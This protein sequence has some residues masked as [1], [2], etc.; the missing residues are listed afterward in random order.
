MAFVIGEAG[1]GKTSLLHAFARRAQAAQPGLIVASGICDD[2]TGVGDPYL[3]FRDV[4]KMLSGDVETQWAAGDISRDHAVRLWHL[5][6]RTARALV[7]H[8]PD[9]IGSFI[10]GELLIQRVAAYQRHGVAKGENSAWL[11]RLQAL[12][13]QRQG[14]TEGYGPDQ[15]RVFEAYAAVLESLATGGPLL[16]LLD[17]LHWAD[18]SSIGLMSHLGRRIASAASPILI[19]GAYRPE[20]MAQDRPWSSVEGRG[21]APLEMVLSELKRHFGDIWIDLEQAE[22]SGGR[23]FVDALLD[24]EPNRL[25]EGFRRELARHTQGQPLFTI[26]LLQELRERG[27]LQRDSQGYWEAAP[28]LD[29]DVLPPRVEGVIEKRLGRL[30]PGLAEALTV[31]S[32]EGEAFTAEAVARVLD[33]DPSTLVRRLSGE[34]VKRHR[35]LEAQGMQRLGAQRLSRYRF[36][37]NLFQKYLYDSLDEVERAYWHEA[38]GKALQTL[39]GDQV[40]EIAVQLARH[41]QEADIPTLAVDYL[42]R[43]GER[44]MRLAANE[45]AVEHLRQGLAVLEALPRSVEQ[46]Q[47]QLELELTLG[48]AERNAGRI[49]EALE[50]FQRSADIARE[51]GSAQGLARAALGYEELRWRFNLPTEPSAHV[52]ADALAAL[53]EEESVLRVRVWVNLVRTLMPTSSPEQFA[54]MSRQALEMARR[55][56]DPLALYDA[57]YLKLIGERR[58][59]ES[60]E[61]FGAINEMLRLAPSLNDRYVAIEAYAH[62]ILENLELGEP[63]SWQE[64]Y[65]EAVR[66]SEMLRQPFYDYWPILFEMTLALLVGRFGEAERIAQQALEVGQQ[67]GVENTDGIFGIQMFTIRR[68]QGRLREL[69]PVVKMLVEEDSANATWRPGLALLY[70]E[71]NLWSETREVF[72][73]LAINGFSDLP[74]DAVW[75]TC[76]VYLA[77][78]C[79][80]LGDADRAAMLYQLLLPYA[81]RNVVV[82][83]FTVCYGAAARFLGLLATT[84]SLWTEAEGHF[85]AALEM[86]AKLGARPWLAHTQHQYA[87]MLLTRDQPGDRDR[88]MSLLE[89]ALGTARELGMASLIEK[90]EE[91]ER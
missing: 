69:A 5:L 6:P 76:I 91:L 16:L 26:E 49:V 10:P 85:E 63:Q 39:Y 38:V 27:D 78:V 32:V 29:W 1:R 12:A 54:A 37:H 74:R 60:E 41:F 83:F 11:D 65:Q 59:E 73:D 79:A 81:G 44:A 46:R 3:P 62:R 25:G 22:P 86:N 66:L 82:G 57:L 9:L 52:L 61:R 87:A 48:Q 4:L 33:L 21:Q 18:L 50:T 28:R 35:L 67:L 30:D 53:G 43:A 77:E 55:V 64:D 42:R 51:L 8:G 36:R 72:E 31:A 88:A 47:V 70:S 40:D 56:D 71:L 58:P 23:S 45:E 90:I 84:M 2:Y 19:V 80:F 15:Q 17:D 34:L 13:G 89:E 75:L 7:K 68:E 20:E 24:S 14:P